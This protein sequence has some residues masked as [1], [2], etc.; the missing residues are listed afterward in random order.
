MLTQAHC[1]RQPC[2]VRLGLQVSCSSHLCALRSSHWCTAGV[3]PAT[4]G[5]A[6]GW[7]QGSAVPLTFAPSC[8]QAAA[9]QESAL[10]RLAERQAGREEEL[11]AARRRCRELEAEVADLQREVAL[12]QEQAAA[13]K[14]V[15]L[16]GG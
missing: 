6:P 12:H 7:A 5:R 3:G 8:A 9:L 16:W 1:R 13:L 15:S 14:E 4:D 10:L 11:R 2:C